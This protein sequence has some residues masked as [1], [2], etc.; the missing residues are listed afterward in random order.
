VRILFA[1]SSLPYPTSGGGA[2]R[3]ELLLRALSEFADIDCAWITP[4]PLAPAHRDQLCLRYNLN[5]LTTTR[6][7]LRDQTPRGLKWLAD[8]APGR[9]IR[10]FFDASRYRWH[11]H[12]PSVA[13]LGSLKAYDLIVARYLQAA[14]TFDLFG[15]GP[16]VVL[17]VD[18][19]DPDR[20]A[21]RLEHSG[22]WKR[23]TLARTLQQS[24][25]AHRRL[26]PQASALWVA[27]PA[28]LRHP[29]LSRALVLPNIPYAPAT[30]TTTEHP[31]PADPAS[32]LFIMVGTFSYSANID[33]ARAFIEHVWPKVGSR[34]PKAEFHVIGG[35]L[36]ENL[37][38]RWAKVP[39]VRVLGFVE[40]LDACYA[41]AL[42]SVAPILAG[43][44]TNIKVLE[45][46]RHARVCILTAVA[47]RGFA[48]TLPVGEACLRGESVAELAD[49]CLS[50]L[51]QP[52]RAAAMG[53]YAHRQ[54]TRLHT[55]ER[56]KKTVREG[57][58]LALMSAP[59]TRAA[60]LL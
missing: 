55:Y 42:A 13:R 7:I 23:L 51:A 19:Y 5:H 34:Y 11:P 47:H 9:P 43:G 30:V 56:F 36:P 27:N 3:T 25:H 24:R 8:T 15:K 26:L 57:C 21:Q 18:D 52:A 16:P 40:N 17:D 33:G 12:P 20:L 50:L 48:D 37:R 54:V 10:S 41:R 58:E 46:A 6:E 14:A 38:Q 44:G 45:S 1:S 31:G 39:G 22:A 53:D 35:G 59:G 49:H 4:R 2:Q 28:D 32:S 60:A 29:E